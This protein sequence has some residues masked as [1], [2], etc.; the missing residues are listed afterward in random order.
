MSRSWQKGSTR[1]WRKLRT[2]VL[3]AN[4]EQ[5]GGTCQLAIP[6]VCQG[7]ASHVHHTHGRSTT[8]D[9]PRY[10][11]ATCA[12]CNLHTG[13]PTRRPDPPPRPRT[14]W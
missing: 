14:R 7:Q 1:R 11:I 2:R 6:G 5:N 13:D 3:A 10:L 4:L 8:G 9:D 12:A